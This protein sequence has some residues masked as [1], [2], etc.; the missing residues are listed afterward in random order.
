[1]PAAGIYRLD[2]SSPVVDILCYPWSHT[3][4]VSD[5]TLCPSVGNK[6]HLQSFLDLNKHVPGN[7]DILSLLTNADDPLKVASELLHDRCDEFLQILSEAVLKRTVD[8]TYHCNFCA[9]HDKCDNAH[10]AIMFSGGIDSMMLAYMVDKC[11]PENQTIDLLN[12][13]FETRSGNF[14]VPDRL[15][16]LS[17]LEELNPARKYNFVEVVIFLCFLLVLYSM[18]YLCE[19]YLCEGK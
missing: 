4:V 13:A 11:L 16:G 8:S 12:V 7:N 3:R 2:L 10:I 18:R 5:E 6:I 15:T 19:L 1:M 9:Q 17:A 14:D